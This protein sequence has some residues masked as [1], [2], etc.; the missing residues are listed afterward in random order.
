[1]RKIFLPEFLD[2]PC[3]SA[4]PALFLAEKLY[5]LGYTTVTADNA[6][7]WQFAVAGS[8]SG[9]PGYTP[10]DAK[11]LYRGLQ[12]ITQSLKTQKDLRPTS[13]SLIG[14]SL[15]ASQGL[16]LQNIDEQKKAFGFAKVLLINPPVD[17][18]HAIT[19]I[20]HLYQTGERLSPTRKTRVFNKTLDVGSALLE[21]NGLAEATD[22]KYLQKVFDQLSF[23]TAD[24]SFLIGGNFRDSLRDV[25]FASQQVYDLKILKSPVSRYRR[26]M[27]YDESRRFSFHDYLSRFV[28]PTVKAQKDQNYTIQQ[29][30][31]E[32]SL[33]QFATQIQNRKNLFLIHSQDDFILK[34]GDLA[35]LKENFG[36]RALIFPYGGHCGAMNFPQFSDYLTQI[37]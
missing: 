14:Y 35:W 9:I 10:Q 12:A 8:S 5:N 16:F 31:Q 1:M 2:L 27:R 17:L 25:I 32:A 7:S 22:L 15:G 26:N 23:S 37:F 36:N 11:D 6:F 21:E 3:N 30:N 29:M 34:A 13:Y 18:F 28:F 19:Q 4:L 20:D 24:M 33:Y